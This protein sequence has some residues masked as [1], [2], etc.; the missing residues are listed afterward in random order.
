LL[1]VL[2]ALLTGLLI[3]IFGMPLLMGWLRRRGIGQFIR[4]DGPQAHLAKEGT[5]TMGGVLIVLSTLVALLL[6][7]QK[8]QA[9]TGFAL[10]LALLGGGLL[11]FADDFTKLRYARSLGLKGRTKLFWQLALSLALA[12]LATQHFG[13]DT[14]LYWFRS[15]AVICDLGPLYYLLVF[16][17]IIGTS[18]AVNLTDGLDGLA[19]GTSVLVMT[20]YI[21]IAFTQFRNHQYLYTHVQGSLD[22]A[23][24]AG[25][26]MGSCVGFLWWNSPPAYI[27]MGDTGSLA[28]GCSLATVAILSKTELLL[29]ILGGLFVLETLSVAIQVLVFKA[30]RKRVFRMAPLHHHFELKG[31]SEVTTLIRLWIVEGF[32]VGIGFIIFY[33]NYVGGK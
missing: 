17:M 6:W 26:L 31:W 9:G 24:F 7:A 12:Y 29:V 8:L 19:A 2:A 13:V 32:F 28:L 15:D 16:V 25:A 5:P 21:L 27:F 14:K 18:N 30:T 22:I 1:R 10:G 33:I 20:A 4:E 23:I 11:G 3:C